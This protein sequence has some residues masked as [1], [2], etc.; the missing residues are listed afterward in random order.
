MLLVG[1][2]P[3]NAGSAR[4]CHRLEAADLAPLKGN[5]L[6]NLWLFGMAEGSFLADRSWVQQ[7]SPQCLWDGI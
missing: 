3:V 6:L 5:W 1:A 7:S 4:V 2:H